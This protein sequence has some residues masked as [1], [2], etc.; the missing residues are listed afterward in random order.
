[1]PRS[2]TM[3]AAPTCSMHPR[4]EQS[5][6][7]QPPA[8]PK[9]SC[10]YILSWGMAMHPAPAG[11]MESIQHT[12][13][14]LPA[15]TYTAAAL[16]C[17]YRDVRAASIVLQVCKRVIPASLLCSMQRDV[18]L[19]PRVRL[20]LRCVAFCLQANKPGFGSDFVAGSACRKVARER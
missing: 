11:S 4:V 18:A 16:R 7:K 13:Q 3:G 1:M 2:S 14:W 9:C 17:T 6:R 15:S 10:V 8:K 19:S 20:C 5:A 12:Q